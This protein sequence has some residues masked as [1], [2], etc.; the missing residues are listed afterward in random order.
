MSEN[1][2][3]DLDQYRKR[4]SQ[5]AENSNPLSNKKNPSFE[6]KLQDFIHRPIGE[7]GSNNELIA[8]FEEEQQKKDREDDEG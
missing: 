1:K 5:T 8:I 3:V 2:I 7:T 6:E 4:K